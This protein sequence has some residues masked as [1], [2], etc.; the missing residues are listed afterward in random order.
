MSQQTVSYPP[1]QIRADKLPEHYPRGWFCLGLLDDFRPPFDTCQHIDGFG[2]TVQV[3][4]RGSQ[5]EVSLAG[6]VLPSLQRNRLLLCWYDPD[7]GGPLLDQQPPV[8]PECD[9]R[10]WSRWQMRHYRIQANC[11]ELIDNMAD[12]AHFGPVHGAQVRSFRNIMDG[13]TFVQEMRGCSERLSAESELYSYAKYYGPAYQTTYMRGSYEGLPIESYLLL[14][15]VP[16][17]PECFDIRYAVMVK[18]LAQL[19][20]AENRQLCT[21]YAEKAFEAFAEDVAIWHNKTRIDN[22]ILCDGDGPIHK[23]RSWYAQFYQPLAAL[24]QERL[25]YREY[26]LRYD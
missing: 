26:S 2:N 14:S 24:D 13:H 17:S 5:F 9:T 25:R 20:E 19:N 11:R 15:H 3:R 23:L 6:Q 18:R 4:C 21:I 12:A 22:P 1:Y 10:Q 16:V 8:M 7:N